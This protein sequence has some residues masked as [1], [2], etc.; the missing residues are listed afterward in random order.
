MNEVRSHLPT[1]R[2]RLLVGALTVCLSSAIGAAVAPL[3]ASADTPC[4]PETYTVDQDLGLVHTAVESRAV[5]NNTS[6][7]IPVTFTSSVAHTISTT[8]TSSATISGGVKLGIINLTVS[9]TL[10]V[11]TTDSVTTTIGVNVGPVQ[12]PPG[13]TVF[14][15]W[16]VFQ[17]ETQGTYVKR[18]CSPA[19]RT[20]PP[21]VATGIALSPIA[22]G[23]NVWQ[24]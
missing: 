3:A 6:S 7:T 21:Q 18:I 16:G 13:N 4:V 20:R 22:Q 9:A 15:N 2:R 14:G 23:W 17:Q 12:V 8:W 11:A 24:Q 5:R 1:G 19:G 10:G